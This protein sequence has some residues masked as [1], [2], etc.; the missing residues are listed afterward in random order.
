[1]KQDLV[2]KM[3]LILQPL[4]LRR[5]KAD[6]E[7]MLPKKRE[8]VLYAPLT[9]E[10]TDLYTAIGDK[11]V[12]TRK[13]LEERVV[14]RLTK[15]KTAAPVS[16]KSKPKSKKEVRK[17]PV[18]KEVVKQEDSESDEELPLREMVLRT[19]ATESGKST[20][21]N[22]FQTMMQKRSSSTASTKSTKS[23]RSMK[24]KSMES[25]STPSAKSAKS[26]R[27]S[28]PATSVRGRKRN[29][30]RNYAEADATDEDELSDDEF[31]QKLAVEADE[32]VDEVD[33]LADQDPE[34]VE[35]TRILEP[36]SE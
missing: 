33:D 11:K 31:E 28:T 21:K 27:A 22:A 15:A 29:G 1:M 26:S 13:F 23:T 12:D 25:M 7:H 36:A 6:V 3:H 16:S 19:K 24:R 8:Y 35:R 18:K 10:Q 30:R 2:K 4:L 20:P 14:E 17:T 34:E 9:K 5:V 32:L